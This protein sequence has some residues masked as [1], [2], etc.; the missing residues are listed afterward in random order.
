MKTMHMIGNAHLDPVWLWN[1]REGFQ[2]N[3]ATLKSALDRMDEFDDFI[4]TSSSAQFYEWVEENAPELFERIKQRV[5]EGRWVICGGWWIQPDCNLPC[6]ES[7]ARQALLAQNYFYEKFGITATTGYCV[8]SFGHN[9][10][11]PQILK[12]SG[13]DNYVFQRPAA[14]EKTDLPGR[15]F[16][17]EAPDGSRV[18]TY[19]LP[20]TY[21]AYDF[22]LVEKIN[23]C[24]NEYSEGIDH[25]MV[26]YGVGN[27]GGGP[28]INNINM[29]HQLMEER[30][31]VRLVLSDPNRFFD[32]VKDYDLPV[33]RD[34]LQ[35][36]APGCYSAESGVKAMNRRAENALL[37]A[38][39]F[40]VMAESL[41]KPVKTTEL[42]R[43]W[44]NVLFNQ[45]HDT[46]AGSSLPE[47]YVDARNELGEAVSIAS[48]CSNNAVQAVSFD[49]NIPLN[50]STLPLVVFNPHSW[51]V[52]TLVEFEKGLFDDDALFE[53]MYLTDSEGNKVSHQ[54]MASVCPVPN[55][56]RF[57][58]MA[59]VPALGYQVYFAN[60]CDEMAPVP[61]DC[62]AFSLE[63][64]ILKVTFDQARGTIASVLDKRTG[65]ELLANPSQVAVVEDL[66]DTWGHSLTSLD[67]QIGEF[68]LV[69]ARVCDNGP[70][71]KA[72][73]FKSAYGNSS[74]VQ[75]F[76]LYAGE[77]KIRVKAKLNW[78]DQ[79]KAVK[80]RF[81]VN[82]KGG[83]ASCEIPYGHV[84]KA[85]NGLEEPMQRWAD[86]SGDDRG[87]SIVNDSKYSVDFVN[88]T[89]GIT[90]LRSPVYAHHDPFE[91]EENEDY[92]YMDQGIS[93]FQYLVKIHSGDWRSAGT[94]KEA[95]LLN[96]G[97][98]PMFETFHAGSLPQKN[99]FISVDADNVIVSALKPSHRGEGC[100]LRLYESFGVQTTAA[101]TLFGK[102]VEAAFAPY[103][104]KT[105]IF[106]EN[107][108]RELNLIEWEV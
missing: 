18:R 86:I 5:Q 25:L 22:N 95:E 26:F 13:M 15:T 100:V 90:A 54:Y 102:T 44:K 1:W 107:G 17:W 3:K 101:I 61:Q 63:N 12:K 75:T 93:E 53:H 85:Q 6:G 24:L 40:A 108:C 32:V 82:V 37:A 72:V 47:A 4:F 92:T 14:H 66:T 67:R 31:D 43:G 68:R 51:P 94:M 78:Q 35:H 41:G 89:I 23:K 7:F 79:R 55:R 106:T 83:T 36:H 97:V 29:L 58:F 64:E 8:D 19:Q 84:I 103:E 39:K 50:P 48:R 10:M 96:Q 76:A 73:R 30:D 77:D 69:W 38:E 99:G 46:I 104:I 105:L 27:H 34:E 56:K 65:L 49:V 20:F 9:A 42:E 2:E 57:T 98:V 59:E 60:E 70:V 11:L 91:L 62:D 80:L 16:L 88:D 71:R 74:L 21:T 28:T 81:P 45:F 87:M 33:V 52:R